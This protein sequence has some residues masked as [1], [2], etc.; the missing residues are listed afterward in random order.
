MPHTNINF[1]TVVIQLPILN[2]IINMKEKLNHL[3]GTRHN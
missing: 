3:N 1:S 2:L